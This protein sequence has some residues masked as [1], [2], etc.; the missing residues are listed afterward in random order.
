METT[1]R[2]NGENIDNIR[3][4]GDNKAVRALVTRGA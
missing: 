1:W 3:G 4:R 2:E